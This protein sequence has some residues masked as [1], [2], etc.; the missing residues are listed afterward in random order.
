MSIIKKLGIPFSWGIWA[1]CIG[2]AGQVNV[3]SLE[4]DGG[5]SQPSSSQSS[6]ASTSGL[7]GSAS[8]GSTSADSTSVISGAYD[9]PVHYGLLDP[10]LGYTRPDGL[11]SS[12]AVVL[13][14]NSVP[15]FYGCVD[16]GTWDSQTIVNIQMKSQSDP[17]PT[18]PMDGG[19]Q[20]PLPLTPRTYDIGFV[21]VN[22]NTTPPSPSDTSSL[23]LLWVGTIP[24]APQL[25][26]TLQAI[27]S[28]G[29][30]TL[31]TVEPGHVA[32]SFHV[33]V[34]HWVNGAF[35]TTTVYDFAG[36]FD[37]T[38]CPGLAN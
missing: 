31:T 32:G 20:L 38:T 21:N 26:V 23:A 11:Y 16:A 4:N 10:A 14:G 19:V 3:S 34:V 36:T 28:T 15:A 25:G 9:F 7:D 18:F 1:G 5:T 35:D 29:T 27:A 33:G 12:F 2:C 17:G 30:V 13:A 37:T 22:N 6:S 24:K 8:S